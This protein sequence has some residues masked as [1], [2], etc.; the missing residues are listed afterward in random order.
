MEGGVLL[1]G[2]ARTEPFLFPA[3]APSVRER[4]RLFVQV[5]CAESEDAV[6]RTRQQLD[7]ELARWKQVSAATRC[8][9]HAGAALEL[10]EQD[11][12]TLGLKGGC[13]L[14]VLYATGWLPGRSVLEGEP[15]PRLAE[16]LPRVTSLWCPP[17]QPLPPSVL[18]ANSAFYMPRLGWPFVSRCSITQAMLQ[19][20]RAAGLGCEPDC[21]ARCIQPEVCQ[22]RTVVPFHLFFT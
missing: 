7:A 18:D 11:T 5:L 19:V 2:T 10:G 22:V 12:A 1:L 16:L 20:L 6:P 14:L 8:A 3:T 17:Q 13:S 9:A 4:N 21:V 15:D